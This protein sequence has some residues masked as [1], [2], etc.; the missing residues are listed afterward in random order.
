[1]S[2]VALFDV[3]G[4]LLPEPSMERRF[5]G[6]L[7]DRRA[8]G[9]RHLLRSALSIAADVPWTAARFKANKAYL[10]GETAAPFEAMG[11]EFVAAHIVPVLRPAAL[12]AMD[13][14]R[15]AGARMLLL[16]GSLDLLARPLA[17]KLALDDA[18]FGRLELRDGR[19]TGRTRP[20][21]PFGAG[22]A[23]ALVAYAEQH[24]LDLKQARFYSDSWS[25]LPTFALVG[26]ST[27]VNPSPRLER[28]ARER[29]WTIARWPD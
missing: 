22:K 19:F 6:W 16:T 5:L 23:A 1:M 29:G 21:H 13:K 28:E 14:Q 11:A 3:D 27:V 17:Q 12:A 18:L 7:L 24:G 4:T 8:I 2:G 9:W 25:D 20:P 26:H 10:R 15:R